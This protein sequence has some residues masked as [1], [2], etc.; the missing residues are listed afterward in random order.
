[1]VR[2]GFIGLG[3]ISRYHAS[4]LKKMSNAQITAGTDINQ[5]ARVAFA[6]DFGVKETYSDFRDMVK[7]SE[8]DAVIVGLPT[9]L[10]KDGVVAS[11]KAGLHVFCEKPIAMTMKDADFMVDTC[12]KEKVFL[13]IGFVRRYDNNWG[14]LK[15]LIR[16][17]AIG[18]PVIWRMTS[19][20]WHPSPL[21][22]CDKKLGGG[23][24][25]DGAVH[26]YD[27]CIQI[28]GQPDFAMANTV[29]YEK[30]HTGRDTGSAI[31]VFKSGDQTT[32][33]WSW[34]MPRET[35]VPGHSDVIGP[36]GTIQFS[37]PKEKLPKNFDDKKYWAFH[38]RNGKKEKVATARINNMFEEQMNDFIDCVENNKKPRITGEDGR[39][40][41][42]IALAV[43]ESGLTKKAVKIKY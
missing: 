26:N 18:R 19:G 1:M 30:K 17:G 29:R 37:V 6:K 13:Q 31:I 4:F 38:V 12:E 5:K 3:G 14:K 15:E 34:G 36:K 20:A 35:D 40:A 21:W 16:A 43:L 41:L 10:H 27:Y 23:P 28:F 11:A 33:I 22:F 2:I 25:I 42:A 7:K 39:K 24:L 9:G 32:L 8:L